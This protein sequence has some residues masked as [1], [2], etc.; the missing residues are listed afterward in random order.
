MTTSGFSGEVFGF[1]DG[2][3]CSFVVIF[4]DFLSFKGICGA[5]G[6]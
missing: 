1:G 5:S 4:F 2:K 3:S 6:T